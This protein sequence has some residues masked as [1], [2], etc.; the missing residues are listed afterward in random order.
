MDLESHGSQWR[1]VRY[2]PSTGGP[3]ST[4]V[5]P[6]A[7]RFSALV[8]MLANK[9]LSSARNWWTPAAPRGEATQK[10]LGVVVETICLQPS[11][12]TITGAWHEYP[13]QA[14]GEVKWIPDAASGATRRAHQPRWVASAAKVCRAPTFRHQDPPDRPRTCP[15]WIDGSLGHEDAATST[16]DRAG[17]AGWCEGAVAEPDL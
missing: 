3:E 14:G 8:G 13:A 4:T 6:K 5:H 1:L 11:P 16:P 2:Q 9:D 12:S 17:C 10:R 15:R 7:T